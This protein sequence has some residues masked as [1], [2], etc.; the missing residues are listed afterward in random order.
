MFGPSALLQGIN[1]LVLVPLHWPVLKCPPMAG[2]QMST[3]AEIRRGVVEVKSLRILNHKGLVRVR[4]QYGLVRSEFV[5]D[6]SHT[7]RFVRRSTRG[8]MM[9]TPSAVVRTSRPPAARVI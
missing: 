7:L 8:S 9:R 6:R 4:I 2:F 5:H 1:N 3:E